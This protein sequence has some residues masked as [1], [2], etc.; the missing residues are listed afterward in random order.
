MGVHSG[1]EFITHKYV[2]GVAPSLDSSAP[3][4]ALTQQKKGERKQW[5]WQGVT[6]LGRGRRWRTKASSGHP[7][8]M[9]EQQHAVVSVGS[10]H[11]THSRLSLE[12]DQVPFSV[13]N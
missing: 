9:P 4:S 13:V 2:F 10:V 7:E 6:A 8:G 1:S 5:A 3:S 11:L 12:E